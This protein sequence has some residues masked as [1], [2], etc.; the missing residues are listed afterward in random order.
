MVAGN[1]MQDWKLKQVLAKLRRGEI[2]SVNFGKKI[3]GGWKWKLWLINWL[4]NSKINCK[5]K[6]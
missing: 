5:T 4:W 3:W 1:G 2:V 6:E